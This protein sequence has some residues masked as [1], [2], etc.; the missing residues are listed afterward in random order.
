MDII[1]IVEWLQA[2]LVL[3]IF[4]LILA[5]GFKVWRWNYVVPPR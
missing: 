1:T 5:M 3:A 2:L 4:L